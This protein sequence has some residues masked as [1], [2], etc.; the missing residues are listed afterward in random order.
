MY[1]YSRSAKILKLSNDVTGTKNRYGGNWILLYY[2][3]LRLTHWNN[4]TCDVCASWN[5]RTNCDIRRSPS[6]NKISW[7]RWHVIMVGLRIAATAR[8]TGIL[9]LPLST[10]TVRYPQPSQASCK[11]NDFLSSL[12]EITLGSFWRN[13]GHN[14]PDIIPTVH[15]R[16]HSSQARTLFPLI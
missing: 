2:V 8:Q 16:I 14:P 6:R 10:V 13:V 7:S 3:G 9:S 11:S 12:D 5:S 15:P 1:Q 4:G